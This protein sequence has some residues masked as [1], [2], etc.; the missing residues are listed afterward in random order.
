MY[1]ILCIRLDVSYV[2]SATSSYQTNPGSNHWIAVKN[3]L[4]Y[5]RRTKDT[6]LNYEGQEELF[7]IGYTDPSF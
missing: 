2:L 1:D 5:L 4:K 3:I 6:F 7:V